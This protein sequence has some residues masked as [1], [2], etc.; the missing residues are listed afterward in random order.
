MEAEVIDNI[1]M[2]RQ[3]P[4][5]IEAEQALLGAILVNN[6]VLDK[7]SHFLSA[8]HFY[9]P[10]HCRLYAACVSLDAKGKAFNPELLKPYFDADEALKEMGGWTYL[11][12]LASSATTIINAKD[13]AQ[14]IYDLYLRREL[15]NLG[16]NVV[17]TAYEADIDYNASDLMEDAERELFKLNK[18]SGGDVATLAQ[19]TIEAQEIIEKA[20]KSDGSVT[21]ITTG[22]RDLD[23]QLGGF[24]SPDLTL[25]AGR[26]AMG[27]TALAINSAYRAACQNIPIA[28]FSMEMTRDQLARRIISEQLKLSGDKLRLGRVNQDEFSKVA[29]IDLDKPL[30]IDHTSSLSVA[31][32]RSKLRTL[33]SRH[34]I[35]CA[36]IDYLQ[37]MTSREEGRVQQISE[38]SRGLKS[39]AMELQIPIIALSQLSRQVE[40]RDN[41]R[42]LMSDLRDSG[43]LE[44]DADQV[45][46]VYRG[47]YY[48]ENKKPEASDGSYSEWQAKMDSLRGVAELIISKQRHGPTGTIKVAFEKD[49]TSF[50]DLAHG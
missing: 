39:I 44:Q 23:K 33:V 28:F 12:R 5:N 24:H 7:F 3:L 45:I 31:L 11:A 19:A 26:P 38:I 20:Y 47:E 15:I 17:N 46:F 32:L 34:G 48:L 42:P 2:I 41:K 50:K 18:Q 9:E 35:K 43:S 6:R 4:H 37:L 13:Y 29:R 16:E 10:V 36:F 21:G 40:Q 14:T 1:H 30:F 25:L 22:L 49:Y 8:E 27:K